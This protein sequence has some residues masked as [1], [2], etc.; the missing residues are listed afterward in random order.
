MTSGMVT[1]ER[2]LEDTHRPVSRL[3]AGNRWRYWVVAAAAC[4]VFIAGLGFLVGNAT[5]ANTDFEAA[6]SALDHT[7]QQ[8]KDVE[9]QL[10]L[11]RR[12]LHIVTREVAQ[13]TTARAR[14]T[15]QL[16][17]IQTALAN[18]QVT[19]TTKGSAIANLHACLSGVEQSLN[20]LA[21]G[22]QKS[23]LS[24]LNA[25]STS[26]NSAVTTDG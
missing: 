26:C 7:R 4:T 13:A 23:A 20:A 1:I 16:Q 15:T 19:V 18:A 12:D 3:E 17:E 10:T 24:V 5:I 14:D 22:D 25:A 2:S 6:R 9:V 21:V 8:A 11:A